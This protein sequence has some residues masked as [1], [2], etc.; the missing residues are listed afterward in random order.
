M[1]VRR[2]VPGDD[3]D[4]L[5]M[6]ISLWPDASADTHRR[7]MSAWVRR[8]DAVVLVVPRITGEGLA[9]FAEVGARSLAN[10]CE[11]SPVAYLE[12]WYVDSDMR[13]RGIGTA[14]VQA[15]EAWGRENGFHEFASDAELDNV[16]S[17]RAHIAL[18]FRE[19]GRLVSYLKAI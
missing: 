14:L 7:E 13:G 2:R 12:G 9:G 4:W 17:Q 15:A 1:K 5:R 19:T 10:G 3:I 11:T 6:R 18:G 8:S 16:I